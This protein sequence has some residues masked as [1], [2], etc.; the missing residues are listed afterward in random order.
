MSTPQPKQVARARPAKQRAQKP[1]RT[2]LRQIDN[3]EFVANV[4][5][6]IGFAPVQYQLNPGLA[7]TFPTLSIEAALYE[8][9][10]LKRLE[11]IYK[12]LVS[13]FSDD[14]KQGQVYIMWSPDPSSSLPTEKREVLV[15]QAHTSTMPNGNTKLVVPVE[16]F[17]TMFRKYV[18]T[19]SPPI[20][21]DL[22][23]YD[24]GVL[25]VST[26]GNVNNGVSVGELHVHYVID[27]AGRTLNNESND[28]IPQAQVYY[29]Y[30]MYQYTTALTATVS[31]TFATLN[32]APDATTFLGGNSA[33]SQIATPGFIIRL[34]NPGHYQ[35]DVVYEVT[36]NTATNFLMGVSANLLGGST[37]YP[38]NVV[39]TGGTASRVYG[40]ISTW[41]GDVTAAAKDVYLR[42]SRSLA[43][44]A[45]DD[46][47]F[48][49]TIKRVG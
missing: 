25:T 28:V 2:P 42:Y 27:F 6:S 29:N 30:Y 7:T 49:V 9:Y 37:E 35:I 22:R 20:Y 18:R 33:I 16:A 48:F 15:M 13:G 46:E 39:Y 8:T 40:T 23:N 21:S 47:K 3:T 4:V 5:S 43:D 24:F 34:T 10:Q 38:E 11:F 1:K 45:T 31:G 41:A 12:P 14:G 44:T 32:A 17:R 26:D 19:G 36:A